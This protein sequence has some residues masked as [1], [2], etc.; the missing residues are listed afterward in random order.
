MN[1]EVC[2][3]QVRYF[4]RYDSVYSG[5]M[6]WSFRVCY[7]C[8]HLPWRRQ[9]NFL[10][11]IH[12]CQSTRRKALEVSSFRSQLR[13]NFI[14]INYTDFNVQ[15]WV[16]QFSQLRCKIW[17]KLVNLITPTEVKLLSMYLKK[18]DDERKTGDGVSVKDLQSWLSHRSLNLQDVKYVPK[19][20]FSYDALKSCTDY[21]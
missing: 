7:L 10:E 5:I 6:Y 19:P 3:L 18:I 13:D 1:K 8:H 15:F 9:D 14:A 12:L 21:Q 17:N 11:T 2:V 16:I 20:S 4:L